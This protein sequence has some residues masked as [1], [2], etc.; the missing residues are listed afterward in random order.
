MMQINKKNA[1]LKKENKELK[2]QLDQSK[3]KDNTESVRG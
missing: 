1:L 2:Q 3:T